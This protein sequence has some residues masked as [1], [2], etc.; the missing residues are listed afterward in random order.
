MHVAGSGE[1]EFCVV[2]QSAHTGCPYG[3]GHTLDFVCM[4]CPEK[5]VE[6]DNVCVSELTWH[7]AGSGV[8]L[9]EVVVQGSQVCEE[10]I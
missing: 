7:V 5:C 10:H 9:S 2:T 1:Q 8:Q 3:S 4:I 6:H